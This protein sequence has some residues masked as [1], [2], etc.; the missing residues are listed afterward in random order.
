MIFVTYFD[1]DHEYF[2]ACLVMFTAPNWHTLGIM[3]ITQFNHM[4]AFFLNKKAVLQRK[5]KQN[6]QHCLLIAQTFCNIHFI[7]V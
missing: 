4:I 6:K 5:S 3:V 2:R 1:F 7:Y